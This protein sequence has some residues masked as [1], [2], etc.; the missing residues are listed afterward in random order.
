MVGL[1]TGLLSSFI[2]YVCVIVKKFATIETEMAGVKLFHGKLM[3][4]MID[5][6]IDIST[7]ELDRLL[8]AYK[9]GDILSEDDWKELNNHLEHHHVEAVRQTEVRDPARK[10]A[11]A[12]ILASV[13]AR[14]QREQQ[15]KGKGWWSWLTFWKTGS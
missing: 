10:I 11:T 1:I 4:R 8:L 2:F 9:R 7:P 15:K 12:F 5:L 6:A 3:D 13:E 14:R